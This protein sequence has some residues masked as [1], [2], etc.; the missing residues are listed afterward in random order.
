MDMLGLLM[1]DTPPQSCHWPD[2]KLKTQKTT[3][4]QDHLTCLRKTKIAASQGNT[5]ILKLCVCVFQFFM[6]EVA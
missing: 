6:S 5:Q 4:S 2:G 3:V 1:G